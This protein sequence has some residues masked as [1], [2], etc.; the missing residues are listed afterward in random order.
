MEGFSDEKEASARHFRFIGSFHDN[1]EQV[2]L[3]GRF[4]MHILFKAAIPVCFALSL[5]VT[6]RYGFEGVAVFLVWVAIV[7]LY[8]S[9]ARDDVEWIS[10]RI[11]AALSKEHD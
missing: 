4:T 5:L 6:L 7:W 11:R 10:S 9:L 1:G 2:T 3:S 8:R